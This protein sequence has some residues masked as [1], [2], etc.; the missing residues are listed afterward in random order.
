MLT[1]KKLDWEVGD[2]IVW[3]G[4][5]KDKPF[6]VTIYRKQGEWCHTIYAKLSKEE[7]EDVEELVQKRIKDMQQI[8]RNNMHNRLNWSTENLKKNKPC[9]P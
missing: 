9:I 7:R 8:W 6:P 2:I 5:G 4:F 1:P 3:V